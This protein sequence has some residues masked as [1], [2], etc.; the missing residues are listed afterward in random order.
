M[1]NLL[2]SILIF[3]T[4]SFC[5]KQNVNTIKILFYDHGERAISTNQENFWV[6]KDKFDSIEISSS[7]FCT[8]I[9]GRLKKLTVSDGFELDHSIAF[10]ILNKKGPIDTFYTDEFMYRWKK[11]K[12]CYIDNT[13]YFKNKFR[14]IFKYKE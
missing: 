5:F 11:G 10:I 4:C 14:P 2:L 12:S 1:R 7:G 13:D 6:D 9:M 8:S 3:L